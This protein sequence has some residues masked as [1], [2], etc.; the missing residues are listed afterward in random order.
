MIQVYT[1]DKF[2]KQLTVV[3]YATLNIFVEAGTEKQPTSDTPGTQVL[4][5]T[6]SL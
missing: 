1:L 5:C 3:G 6:M 2:Y 4:R